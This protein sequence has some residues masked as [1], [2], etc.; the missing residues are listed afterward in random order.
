MNIKKF[1][2]LS[3]VKEAHFIGI[4][5]SGMFPLAQILQSRKIKVTGSDIYQSD[6]LDK[7]EKLGIHV[8]KSHS[9]LNINNPDIVVYSA[10][11]K[12]ENPE[13][14]AAKKKNIPLIKRSEL[15]GMIF[16]NYKN[17]IGVA[18]THGK[19]TTTSMIASILID[20]QRDPTAI[21]GGTLLKINSNCN[22]GKSDIIVGEACEYMDSYLSLFPSISVINNVDK[23]HLDYFGTFENVKKSFEKYANQTTNLLVLNGDDSNTRECTN[24]IDKKK[25]F[26]GLS[27]ENDFYA[28]DISFKTFQRPEFSIYSGKE[29]LVDIKLKVPGKHNIY[30]ALAA[31]CVCYYLGVEPSIIKDSLEDFSGTHRR[32]EVIKESNGITVADDFAHHPTEIKATLETAMKM[33]FKTVW[34]IFQ[35]H[36]FSR[37]YMLMKDFVNALSLADRV[38]VSDILPVR[39]VNTYGVQSTDLTNK[40]PQSTYIPSFEE[41]TD[42]IIKNAKSG[43]LI[44]TL[45]GGNV[46]KCAEMIA[47]KL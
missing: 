47:N 24:N 21:V 5:G 2:D 36:T 38:I 43:D 41:I 10:A 44:L 1:N 19:T 32:F 15:M 14:Q 11:I 28:K 20:A 30:N 37:T 39:E 45:G 33:N 29:K 34:A 16:K 8:F 25:L 27:E 4:G 12:E 3:S 46:Y 35:P 9:E 17:S 22:I 7:V 42:F 31:F 18:G 13:I 26:F 40:I 6:T 23:D